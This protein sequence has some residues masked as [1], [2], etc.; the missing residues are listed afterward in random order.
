[1][2]VTITSP[3]W[4]VCSHE[5]CTELS[6]LIQHQLQVGDEEVGG[7]FHLDPTSLKLP[8]I[9]PPAESNYL[10]AEG[11]IWG[12]PHFWDNPG[13][14]S[15]G[16]KHWMV[17]WSCYDQPLT[18]ISTNSWVASQN[19][20]QSHPSNV[21]KTFRSWFQS[22]FFVGHFKARPIENPYIYPHS[23][24]S[25]W[26]QSR[27]WE[28]GAKRLRLRPGLLVLLSAWRS[29]SIF[30]WWKRVKMITWGW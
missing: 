22:R 15:K 14:F 21:V 9:W 18:P 5:I 16:L 17:Y 19:G 28:G 8:W 13:Y 26:Q 10:Q 29:A 25:P 7:F 20:P 24:P 4:L 1:M 30:S 23:V 2:N 27:T 11:V 3:C 12:L 6:P